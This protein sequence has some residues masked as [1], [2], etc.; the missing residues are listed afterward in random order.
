MNE[1]FDEQA[2][3]GQDKKQGRSDQLQRGTKQSGPGEDERNPGRDGLPEQ[4]D[5]PV[6]GRTPV[7][8]PSPK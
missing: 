5:P 2:A 4:T 8:I 3:A 1:A 7:Q 6:P